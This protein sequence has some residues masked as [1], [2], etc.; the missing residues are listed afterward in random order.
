[1]WYDWMAGGHGGRRGKDGSNCTAPLFGVGLS[2]QPCE[3]QERLSPVLTTEHSIACDSGGPGQYRGGCGVLKG[4]VLADAEGAV[5]SYCCDRGR[6]VTWGIFGGLPSIPHG[7]T[8]NPGREGE[9][10][11]GT[12][13]SNVPIRAGDSFVR[14]SAGGGGLGDPLDRDPA[15]VLED[16]IDGY[17]SV[18]RARKDYGVV[19]RVID[20]DLCDFSIDP[21]ATSRERDYIRLK[22]REWLEENPYAVQKAYLA[23]EVD[24]LDLVRR[25]GVILDWQ[26]N[27]VLE[28]TTLQ[29]RTM[30]KKRSAAHWK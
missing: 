27:E 4:G 24:K 26:T 6:S 19:V 30:L 16:V 29:F 18:S 11:L 12:M 17:V 9:R 21:E 1:M 2:V 28:R 14:P 25:Y 15:A 10:H 3:G 5:M 22:R 7:V 20:E 8:L 23:G 13:F